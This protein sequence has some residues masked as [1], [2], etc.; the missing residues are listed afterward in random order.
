MQMTPPFHTESE[1]PLKNLLMKAKE[2]SRE[3]VIAYGEQCWICDLRRRFS[4]G[5]RDQA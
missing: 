4:F 3:S 2:E 5:T 1:E